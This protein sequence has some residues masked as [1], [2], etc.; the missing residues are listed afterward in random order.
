[1]LVR[2]TIFVMIPC[3]FLVGCSGHTDYF[4]PPPGPPAHLPTSVVLNVS[5]EKAW[6]TVVPALGKRFFVINTLDKSSGIINL[7]YSGD[8]ELYVNCGQLLSYVKNARGERQYQFA[9]SSAHQQ[10]EVMNSNGLFFVD[11]KMALEG[12]INLI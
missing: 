11:R 1:M 12:R 5:R 10:Y 3:V 8:P 7:S 4:P 2:G 6:Q 9:G